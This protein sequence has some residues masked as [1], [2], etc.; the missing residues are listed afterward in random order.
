MEYGTPGRGCRIGTCVALGT[1][2]MTNRYHSRI[3]NKHPLSEEK[4]R[5][6]QNGPSIH[7]HDLSPHA[8]NV[9]GSRLT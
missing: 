5:Y 7:A 3:A 9:S 2:A 1:G 6:E 4:Q 8:H